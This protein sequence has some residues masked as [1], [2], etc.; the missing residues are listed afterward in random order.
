[1]GAIGL[2]GIVGNPRK[3]K[4][5]DTLVQKVLEGCQS[6][7]A[8]IDNITLCG[9]KNIQNTKEKYGVSLSK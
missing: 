6:Q 8:L 2:T 9:V 3:N 5:S 1:M 7:G 4:N